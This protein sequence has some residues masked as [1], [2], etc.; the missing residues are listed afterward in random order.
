MD[1]RLLKSL[2]HETH[3]QV[4]AQTAWL[5]CLGALFEPQEPSNAVHSR[6]SWLASR[7]CRR[8]LI[9]LAR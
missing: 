2:W 6:R 9:M 1:R 7:R 8:W 4:L 5:G 3:I